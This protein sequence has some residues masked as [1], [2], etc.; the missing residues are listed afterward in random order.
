VSEKLRIDSLSL[1]P[2]RERYARAVHL[3]APKIAAESLGAA[4]EGYWLDSSHFY[5]LAERI[6]PSLDRILSVPSLVDCET[7]NVHAVVPLDDMCDWLASFSKEPMDLE[8]LSSARFDM[9][10]RN[11]LAVSV[12]GRHYLVDI[13]QRRVTEATTVGEKP[14]LFSPDGVY[15]CFIKG[16]DLWLR[17]RTGGVECAMTTDGQPQC[18]YGQR[19]ET[20][21]SA[22]SYRASPTPVGLWS[23]DSQWFLTHQID[24]RTLPELSLIQHAPDSG[25]RP[26]LHSFR[27]AMP[28]DPLPIATYV[29]IH[30]SSGR[31]HRFDDVPVPHVLPFA[32]FS[33]S[34]WFG[35]LNEAWLLKTDRYFKHV[36][37]IRLDLQ[38][39]TSRV[40]MSE[41]ASSGY[42]DIHT[43]AG[44]KPKIRTLLQ[45]DEII[46]FSEANGWGH[47]YLYDSLTGNIKNQITCGEWLVRDIVHIDEA[48]RKVLFLAGGID[49]RDDPAR[50]S[51]CSVNFDGSNFEV[52]LSH[53]GDISL[54]ATA[55]CG[56]SQ[57]RCFRPPD[58]QAG[59]SPDGRRCAVQYHSVD[60]GNRT[61]ILEWNAKPRIVIAA[62]AA[63]R[64]HVRHFTA[65]AAD[66]VTLLHG[67][68]FLPSDFN[69]THSYPLI[70]CIY[71]GPQMAWQPQSFR[72]FYSAQALALSELGCIAL[73]VDTR[74]SPIASRRFHQVGYG[75]LLEPQLADHAAVV[76]HLCE[77]FA[78]ID[79]DRVGIIGQS[80]GGAAAARAMFDY[81]DVFKVGVS[82]CGDHDATFYT[83]QW[84][85]KY[86]GPDRRDSWGAQANSAAA[87]KL[88][89]KLL[90]VSGDMDENVHVSQT[91]A[92]VDALIRA[93]REF[94][95]LIVPNGNHAVLLTSA[96]TQR[97]VWDYFVR[98]LFGGTPPVNF[99]LQFSAHELERLWNVIAR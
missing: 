22:V 82:V 21:L 90:L 40:V 4:V 3:T 52:M 89:G 96:Y 87:Y 75:E 88:Q 9:P 45:T 86:R 99:D 47:L 65:P 26:I 33:Q 24:E 35:G 68:I 10:S 46:W 15:S 79:G 59:V 13:H 93:N 84:S 37:L 48:R 6:E 30:A 60:R 1:T 23:P 25:A 76:R 8:A 11:T 39:G 95:L 41:S 78:F 73:M 81:G 92:L 43:V 54:P 42:L 51:L 55:Q 31:I 97:R 61:E 20:G 2:I 32:A 5:F 98:H 16:H 80:G 38:E 63:E 53:D 14:S 94:D 91:L 17:E 85:D 29:A 27:Y 69:D 18:A 19:S 77:R 57:D 34:A 28:G 56:L 49:R 58:A 66:G 36:D 64:L 12:R 7:G 70:D 74:G 72:T 67:V 62:S 50:R 44:M 83:T 71:P